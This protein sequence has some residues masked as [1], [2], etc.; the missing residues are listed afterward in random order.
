MRRFAAL[1]VGC[2]LVCPTPAAA[3]PFTVDRLLALE[4]L[5]SVRLDTTQRWLVVQRYARYDSAP[6][7]DLERQT[8]LALGR[9]QL[10]DLK[11][12]G[13]ERPLNLPAGAGYT[14]LGLSPGGKRLAVGRMIGHSY[15]LGVVDLDSGEARWL[16]VSPR[17]PQFGPDVVWRSDDEILVAAVPM[18]WPDFQIRFGFETQARLTKMW[19]DTAKGDVAVTAIGSGRYRDLRPKGPQVG[20]V[21]LDLRHNTARPLVGGTIEDFA[22]APDGKTVAAIVEGEDIQR[23]NEGPKTTASPSQFNRLAVIDLDNGKATFPCLK[24]EVM[25]RL[26]AWSQDGREVLAFAR[27]GDVPFSAGRFWRFTATATA[28][29]V[30]LGALTPVFGPTYDTAGTPLGD[31]LDGAPV[32]FARPKAGG[33]ADYWRVTPTGPVNLTAGL[34]DGARALGVSTKA[35]AVAAGAK[36]W[37]VTTQGGKSWGVAASDVV[38]LADPPPGFRGAQNFVPPLASLGLAEGATPTEAWVGP[39]VRAAQDGARIVARTAQGAVQTRRDEHGVQTV[40]W[41]D[42]AGSARPLTAVNADLAGVDIAKP[43]AVHHKSIDGKAVTSWLYLPP[44]PLPGGG[45]P[46]VVVLPYP[47]APMSPSGALAPGTLYMGT[48]PILLAA[49]GYAALVPA[50]PY[51]DGREPIEAMADQIFAAVDAAAKDGLVDGDRVAAWGHS[52]GGYTVVAAAEQTKRLRAVIAGAPTVNLTSAYAMVGPWANTNPENGYYLMSGSGWTET[53]QARMGV[54]PWQAPDLY[55][56]NSPITYVDR[57]TTPMMIIYGDL[58][59][60]IEQPQNLFGALYRQGKDAIFLTYRGET[61][62]VETPGNVRDQYQRIFA[63]LDE[64]LGIVRPQ[65]EVA[66]P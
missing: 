61:H 18:S 28:S 55:Q 36:V 15:E 27:E 54:P 14:A 45:K 5:G 32:V 20:L 25:N 49:H 52:Y 3:E 60:Y 57:I 43:I 12:G 26:L 24:C 7:W 65:T 46:P 59:K 16:G 11:A 64:N 40:S 8:R 63:F 21:T 31:W 33:R 2:A 44:T 48:N 19:A 56:R 29:P 9:I 53:G 41:V 66:A 22:L 58:D 34:P 35:W 51:P 23:L 47:A 17:I 39:R 30:D 42:A 50:M 6:I 4:S 38:P 13:Q 62:V 10:F 37:R 1:A